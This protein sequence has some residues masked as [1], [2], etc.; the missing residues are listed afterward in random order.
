MSI[1]RRIIFDFKAFIGLLQ[2][3]CLR[4]DLAIVAKS[5]LVWHTIRLAVALNL[6]L[7]NITS[8]PTQAMKSLLLSLIIFIAGSSWAEEWRHGPTTNEAAF[9]IDPTS[10]RKDGN[11]RKVWQIQNFAHNFDDGAA[12]SRARMGYDCVN[13]R[14]RMFSLSTH[15]QPMAYGNFVSNEQFEKEDWHDIAP[16]TVLETIL[17][18]VCSK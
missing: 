4:L 15:T 1:A 18:L 13:E 14:A 17:K 10:I 12:S 7:K 6:Q 5:I 3:S 11:V 9:F 8:N 16:G 2:N